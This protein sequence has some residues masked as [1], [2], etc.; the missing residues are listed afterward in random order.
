MGSAIAIIVMSALSVLASLVHP[1]AM[2]YTIATF[3]VSFVFHGLFMYALYRRC[4]RTPKRN[5]PWIIAGVIGIFMLI[6]LIGEFKLIGQTIQSAPT[7]ETFI[8]NAAIF[9][10]CIGLI[11]MTM[12]KR[13]RGNTE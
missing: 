12:T 9:A 13:P 10:A 7:G 3:V 2:H 8:F 6:D 1:I 5:A 11:L 4:N